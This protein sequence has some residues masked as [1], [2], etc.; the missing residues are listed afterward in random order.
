MPESL[1]Q[2]KSGLLG[3]ISDIHAN[4][5]ALRAVLAD[6][7]TCGVE[8][9]LVL[10]DLVAMGPAPVEVLEL[11][12]GLDIVASVAGNTERYVRTGDRPDPTFAEV[13]ADPGELPR[14]VEVAATFAWTRGV[15]TGAGRQHHLDAGASS[16]RC[17][18]PDGATLFAV[19]ASAVSD[20]DQGIDPD[21]DAEAVERL[22]PAHGAD[23]VVGG[24]THQ[25]TDKVIDGVRFL[26]PGSVSN[27][28]RPDDEANYAILHLAEDAH[29]FEL[30]SVTYPKGEAV[31][32][33]NSCGIP[34]SDF[35]LRRYFPEVT[36]RATGAA[37]P[38]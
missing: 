33:I 26:N 13:I 15:L 4:P 27:H 28:H 31:A 9:W 12:D 34:G 8:R 22:F 32:A 11:L 3:V 37:E 16:F 21:L 17:R 5:W 14:L 2:L 24:H 1:T 6:A 38:T 23:L 36:S 30:R 10:G 29:R 35:L 18:L 25:A 20:A 19:H 7:D